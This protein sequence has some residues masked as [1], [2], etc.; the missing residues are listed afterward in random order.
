MRNGET[1]DFSVSNKT[2]HLHSADT[3]SNNPKLSSKQ[4]FLD[5]SVENNLKEFLTELKKEN[6]SFKMDD[7]FKEQ[8]L[9]QI[10][11]R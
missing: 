4:L 1:N 10:E 5:F 7:A 2:Q 6:P 8:V 11:E 9:H 3:M